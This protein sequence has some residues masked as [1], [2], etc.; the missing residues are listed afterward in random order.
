MNPPQAQRI[1]H[2]PKESTTGP[3][4]PPQ[5]Q[6]IHLSFNTASYLYIYMAKGITANVMLI[7]FS[8]KCF[9]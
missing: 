7:N 2:K 6:R 3:K 9:M 4:N 8:H 1:H 5:A